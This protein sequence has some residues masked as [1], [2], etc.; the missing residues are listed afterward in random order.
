[1][2]AAGGVRD[3]KDSIRFSV[4]NGEFIPKSIDLKGIMVLNRPI[5]SVLDA[6]TDSRFR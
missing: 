3:V 6:D 4:K 5:S 2:V 1:M